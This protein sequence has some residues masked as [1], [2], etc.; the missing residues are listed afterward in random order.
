MQNYTLSVIVPALNEE[1][2]IEAA[3]DNSLSALR[4]ENIQGEVIVIND[5]S[6]DSTPLLVKKKMEGNSSAVR[7]IT[8]EKPMG[9]GASFWDGVDQAKGDI[10]VLI[11][12]D[13]ENDPR[14]IFRYYD[15]LGR[16]DMVIP[17][18]FNK[19]V[20]TPF[21]NTVSFLYNFIVNTT[22]FVNFNYTN[23]TILYR[24]SLLKGLDHR[25]AGFFFQTD[26]LI[27]LV[28]RGYLFAEVPQKLG[29]RKEGDSKAI[30][31]SSLLKVSRDYLRLVKDYYFGR[32]RKLKNTPLAQDSMAALRRGKTS[33]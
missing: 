31:L 29:Q 1:K 17:F 24:R 19:E 2:N 27:R 20:R 7:M 9:I 16:V 8:H 32:N 14:E 22:F 21:R 26:I 28:K 11:P 6:T 3:I 12:G 15:L 33:L 23:G 30:A 10:V 18:V 4:E 5:G 13:N 25:S